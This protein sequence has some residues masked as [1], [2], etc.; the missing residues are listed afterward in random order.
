[1]RFH[2]MCIVTT[3]ISEAIRLW[4]DV[5]GFNLDIQMGLPDGPEPAPA[6]FAD[7]GL[8]DDLYKVKGARSK[9]ATFTSKD[10]AHIEVLQCEAPQTLRTPEEYRR[11]GRSGIQE[12]GLAVEDIDAVWEKVRAAGYETQTDYVWDC[13]TVGRSFIFYDFDGNMIQIWQGIDA[14]EIVWPED[15]KAA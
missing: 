7:Q 8:L 2:H 6:V 14:S 13:S 12:L 3:D 15:S 10:G 11:Y 5:L 1:M 9:L 4:R